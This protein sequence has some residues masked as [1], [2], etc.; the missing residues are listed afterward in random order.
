MSGMS[1]F[2]KLVVYIMPVGSLIITCN[3]PS[4]LCLY[5]CTANAHSLL[6]AYLMQVEVVR[7]YLKLPKVQTDEEPKT[8]GL[9]SIIKFKD[10]ILGR[11][12]PILAHFSSYNPIHLPQTSRAAIERIETKAT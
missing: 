12:P 2:Q 9:S 4:A 8:S 10:A 3:F 5:W 7:K 11:Y 6:T 1:K